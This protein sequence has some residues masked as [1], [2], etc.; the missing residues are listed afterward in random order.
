MSAP[1]LRLLYTDK[2]KKKNIQFLKYSFKVLV[3]KKT[4]REIYTFSKNIE[5]SQ[6]RNG[7]TLF[8]V[9]KPNF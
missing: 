6:S 9:L 4:D 1:G 5:L 2:K 7:I 3:V 8:M